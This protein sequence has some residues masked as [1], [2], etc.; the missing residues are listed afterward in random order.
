M[1]YRVMHVDAAVRV[2]S[3]EAPDLGAGY[4]AKPLS[5]TD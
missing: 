2:D 1:L 5:A 3:C 4:G